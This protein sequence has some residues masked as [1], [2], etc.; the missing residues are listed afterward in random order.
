MP[1]IEDNV[2]ITKD[3]RVIPM[4]DMDI[5]HMQGAF[6]N[7]CNRE[8][9]AFQEIA[10]L[11]NHIN[12]MHRLKKTLLKEA[13]RRGIALIYPDQKHPSGNWGKYFEAERKIKAMDSSV[14]AV[15]TTDKA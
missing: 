7:C 9:T 3:Q 8:Y 10:R 2:W 6:L 5:D 14:V 12:T 15:V 4:C 1:Q 13:E 11:H